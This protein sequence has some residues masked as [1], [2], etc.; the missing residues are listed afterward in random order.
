MVSGKVT[1]ALSPKLKIGNIKVSKFE[2][3]AQKVQIKTFSNL[4]FRETT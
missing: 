3:K 2:I 4:V 1:K